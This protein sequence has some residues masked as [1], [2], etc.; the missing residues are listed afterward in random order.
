MERLKGNDLMSAAPQ[1]IEATSGN[2]IENVLSSFRTNEGY[3]QPNKYEVT[4]SPPPLA[5]T[6][7]ASWPESKLISRVRGDA[8]EIAL[9]CESI[10]LPGRNLSSTP[11]TNVHGPLREVVNN[12]NFADS[13]PMVFQAS[14]DLRE[15]V[16][17]EKWQYTAFNPKTWNVGY[18][19]DYI[20]T[21]D[22][23]ILDKNDQR[24]YGL[25]LHECF[26]KSIAPTELS[27]VSNNEIIKLSIDMNFRY[28]TSLDINQE[29]EIRPEGHRVVRYTRKIF[30]NLPAVVLAATK[31]TPLSQLDRDALNTDLV[32]GKH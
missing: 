22:I 11:D 4:I 2:S 24:K 28:W 17:F 15:R 26:P 12:V 13:I 27:Y 6:M 29:K 19:N 20:G 25:R 7:G 21:V 31:L 3:A 23:Y 14:A 16:F 18:Y 9:R 5:G 30:S 8:Q 10:T 32:G 1:F